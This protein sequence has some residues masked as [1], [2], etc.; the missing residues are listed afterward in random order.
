[1]L[2]FKVVQSETT[3]L[4]MKNLTAGSLDLKTCC[5]PFFKLYHYV[6][7][8]SQSIYFR[9]SIGFFLQF[10]FLVWKNKWIV[11][12]KLFWKL[13]AIN[14]KVFVC[15]YKLKSVPYH[16]S[17]KTNYSLGQRNI[18]KNNAMYIVKVFGQV[19]LFQIQHPLQL[20]LLQH[21]LCL[22]KV[23][24]TRTYDSIINSYLFPAMLVGHIS[25]CHL[26]FLIN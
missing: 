21:A 23:K 14:S 19:H 5:S 24:R 2:H 17:S 12:W 6:N 1:M 3:M 7:L 16:L 20:I 25:P 8:R 4:Y 18:L 13:F 10:Q 9:V 26:L 15:F 11:E 22:Q